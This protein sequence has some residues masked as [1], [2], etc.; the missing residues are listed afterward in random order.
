MMDRTL[1]ETVE[2]VGL[3]GVFG[4]IVECLGVKVRGYLLYFIV[5]KNIFILKIIYFLLKKNDLYYKIL[6]K[7]LIKILGL[8]VIFFIVLIEFYS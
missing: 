4:C 7:F 2:G 5:I 6:I 3:G 8:K 1:W